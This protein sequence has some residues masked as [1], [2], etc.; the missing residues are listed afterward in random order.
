MT[1]KPTYEELDQRVKELEKRD[2]DRNLSIKRQ[3]PAGPD[4]ADG[5]D[6]IGISTGFEFKRSCNASGLFFGLR[7]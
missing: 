1:E 6:V 2:N 7:Q 4:L 3:L 5:G